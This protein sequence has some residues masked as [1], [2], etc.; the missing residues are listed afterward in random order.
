MTTNGHKTVWGADGNTSLN[1][2][3]AGSVSTGPAR[4]HENSWTSANPQPRN[5]WTADGDTEINVE[6][7]RHFLTNLNAA[8]AK[9]TTTSKNKWF[10][11]GWT[12]V[13]RPVPQWLPDGNST[14]SAKKEKTD[15][16][17]ATPGDESPRWFGENCW[18]SLNTSWGGGLP[19]SHQQAGRECRRRR[20][21]LP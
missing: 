10:E 12:T 4:W 19:Q 15:D 6:K 7:S 13:N 20:E 11:D 3:R 5:I 18:T 21:I 2:D 9:K 16:P 14:I 17:A 8:A 1:V